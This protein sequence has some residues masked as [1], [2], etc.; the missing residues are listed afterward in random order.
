PKRGRQSRPTARM[1]GDVDAAIQRVIELGDE[2]MPHPDR[3]ELPF[4]ARLEQ[5]WQRTEAAGRGRLPV[6]VFGAPLDS[7]SIAE[8]QSAGVFRC[9]FRIPAAARDQVL[10]ALDRAT[11]LTRQVG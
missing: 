10:P 7:R 1:G 5:F 6:T 2:W 8:F 3:G 11:D 4:T 9:V